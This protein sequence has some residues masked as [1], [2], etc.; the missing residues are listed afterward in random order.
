MNKN[1][2]TDVFKCIDMSAGSSACWPWKL[3]P[4]DQGRPTFSVNG[5]KLLAYRIVY[6]LVTGDTLGRAL[7]R[8]TCD[9]PI[10][11][12]PQHLLK[13]THN[14]NM[15]DMRERE[16]HGQSKLV[17]LAIRKLAAEGVTHQEIAKRY[18]LGRSTVTEIVGN[19]N[20]KYEEDEDASEI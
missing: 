2:H 20:Y 8:H 11:C 6:E 4:N 12:N 16:R 3:A 10:C 15:K 1:K 5:K 7:V 17:V 14:E 9:N 18:G 13:G 19:V